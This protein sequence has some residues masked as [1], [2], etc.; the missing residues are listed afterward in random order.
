MRFVKRHSGNLS[1]MDS[2]CVNSLYEQPVSLL[3]ITLVM[4]PPT[5]ELAITAKRWLTR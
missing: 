1:E 5:R 2:H 3:Q 4:N